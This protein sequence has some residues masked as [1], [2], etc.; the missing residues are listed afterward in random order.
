MP[1]NRIITKY[2]L[3]ALDNSLLELSKSQFTTTEE[4]SIYNTEYTRFDFTA[5]KIIPINHE[6]NDRF[7]SVNWMGFKIDY[8]FIKTTDRDNFVKSDFYYNDTI[9]L[10]EISDN[11]MIF[12]NNILIFIDGLITISPKIM[13][14][15]NYIFLLFEYNKKIYYPN[16][17]IAETIVDIIDRNA[18]ITIY[19][20]PNYQITTTDV[21]IRDNRKNNGIH[22]LNENSSSSF[23]INKA[24]MIYFSFI[25]SRD[26]DMAYYLS[27]D[28]VNKLEE[29]LPKSI[30]RAKSNLSLIKLGLPYCAIKELLVNGTDKYIEIPKL[31]APVIEENIIVFEEVDEGLFRFSH[32]IRLKR[33]Y[34]NILEVVNNIE[35]RKLKLFIFSNE[36]TINVYNYSNRAWLYNYLSKDSTALLTA[37]KENRVPS[38]IK[39]FKP[40]PKISPKI[41]DYNNFDGEKD[42]HGITYKKKVMTDACNYDELSSLIFYSN[43]IDID[44]IK[45]IFTV[46]DIPNIF[47]RTFTDNSCIITDEDV[48]PTQFGSE[49]VL[50]ISHCRTQNEFITRIYTVDGIALFDNVYR[51]YDGSYDY[52][53]IP[54][55]LL[56]DNSVL[57]EIDTRAEVDVGYET[58]FNSL[59][60]EYIITPYLYKI[61]CY[62]NNI[63]IYDVETNK[64]L[65]RDKFDILLEGIDG[66]FVRTETTE[67]FKK[68]NVASIRI[69]DEEL[70]GRKLI[71]K[72]VN[73]SVRATKIASHIGE[74]AIFEIPKSFNRI[75]LK[76]HFKVYI[77]GRMIPNA[78]LRIA[79]YDDSYMGIV[80]ITVN[81]ELYENDRVECFYDPIASD[82]VFFRRGE[83]PNNHMIN[84]RAFGN[85]MTIPLHYKWNDF[86]INGRKLHYSTM[87]I[88]TACRFYYDSKIKSSLNCEVRMRLADIVNAFTIK[89]QQT[90]IDEQIFQILEENGTVAENFP[91]IENT[92]TDILENII[93]SQ[94]MEFIEFSDVYLRTKYIKPFTNQVDKFVQERFPRLLLPETK[95]IYIETE[96]R[97]QPVPSYYGYINPNDE[98]VARIEPLEYELYKEEEE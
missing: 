42:K 60:D 13:I 80:S 28:S 97:Y 64:L 23:F 81:I 91:D 6:L 58:V 56:T 47:D 44:N 18:K 62:I 33:H 49:H 78:A 68:V 52:T 1:S 73:K 30:F 27:S 17:D 54:R 37:Y 57:I 82:V 40:Y 53:F 67:N 46:G 14:R 25:G 39:N 35:N 43:L 3:D 21:G 85:S 88:L 95:D 22:I 92:E 10:K 38:V 41:K 19:F 94:A 50:F 65:D 93:E 4:E 66:D 32:D 5:D 74:V 15:E 2:E 59:E 48:E 20:T 9:T 36:T 51:Y 16:I 69:L 90:N 8:N 34:A 98:E 31:H 61:D 77:N 45:T 72:V 75:G 71:I 89:K 24:D 84:I 29:Y 79:E 55:S 12:S 63:F 86:Y 83:L 76:N 70:I 96:T 87:D 26:Y 7:V 11:Y